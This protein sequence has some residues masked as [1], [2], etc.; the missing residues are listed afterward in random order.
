MRYAVLG[1]G[2]VGRTL[3]A[4]L[5]S[6]GHEVVIGTRDPGAT[7]GRAAPRGRRGSPGCG[8]PASRRPRATA[9]PWSTPPAGRS[10]SPR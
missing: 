6:L 8:S 3:A 2:I 1:T 7:A 9:T 5:A 10:A 4:R